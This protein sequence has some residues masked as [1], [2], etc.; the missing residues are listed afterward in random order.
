MG[1]ASFQAPER[2]R[3]L[4]LGAASAF[5]FLVLA[6]IAAALG[7]PKTDVVVFLNG[8]KLTGEV[9]GLMRGQLSFKTDAAG[10]LSI[11]WAQIASLRSRQL[12][13]VELSSGKRHLGQAF[14]GSEAGRV[15]IAASEGRE[16]HEVAFV[17]V[18]RMDPIDQGDLV[19]RL[20]GYVTAGYDYTKANARQQLTF[21]GGLSNRNEKRLLSADGSFTMTSQD[22]LEDSDRFDASF[23]NKRFLRHRRFWQGF[24]GFEGND[25]LGLDLRSTLGAV[26]GSFVV[27][28]ARQE[29][30]LY[31]GLAVTDE[32]FQT[33]EKQQSLEGVLGTSYSFFLFNNPEANLDASFMLLPSLTESGRLRSELKLRSRYEIVSDLFFEISLY[34]SYDSDPDAEVDT[35]SDYGVTTSLGYSF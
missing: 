21:T 2:R 23:G 24:L 11:E 19:A 5:L 33:Q 17:D 25:E 7:A 30:S 9:K 22:G 26:Y 15:R 35:T 1:C 4:Q 27:Q 28:D 12:L 29:W 14:A 10:T 6:P 20:D 16:G 3:S 31:T 32:H 34:H 13:Q 18:V 8:D